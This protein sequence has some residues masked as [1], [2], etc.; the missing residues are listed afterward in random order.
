MSQGGTITLPVKDT[1]DLQQR[2]LERLLEEVK[3]LRR[4]VRHN[5]RL[6]SVGTLTAMVVHEFNNILTPIINY[7]ELA[8][9]DERH[10]AK[11]L[12]CAI[13]AG[14]RATEICKAIL[15]FSKDSA[16]NR[17]SVNLSSLVNDTLKAMIGERAK[18]GIEFV[19]DIPAGIDVV[20]PTVELQQVIMN[21]LINAR[22]AVMENGAPGKIEVTTTVEPSRVV[23]RVCDNG[24]G[25]PQANLRKVFEPFFTTK[26]TSP[27]GMSGS[28]LGLSICHEIMHSM[29]GKISVESTPGHGAS[30][31]L[32]IPMAA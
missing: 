28:G 7:A 14:A 6:A 22:T 23:L 15:N 18:D 26:N 32:D 16:H 1:V 3:V 5:Q 11:A 17:E 30:F 21:L 27:D 24:V 31:T 29:G 13:D 9:R 25:I 2:E 10:T 20:A 12:D 19:C 4:R 8:K